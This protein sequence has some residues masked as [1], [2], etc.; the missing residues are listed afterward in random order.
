M[1]LLKS[2]IAGLYGD[3]VSSFH[4]PC[5][6]VPTSHQHMLIF[7]CFDYSHPSGCEV[8]SYNL[9]SSSDREGDGF[10]GLSGSHS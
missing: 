2:G 1:H 7:H 8:V 5:R 4:Q 6:V 9:L 10:R 3:S